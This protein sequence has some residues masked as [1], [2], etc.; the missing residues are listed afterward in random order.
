MANDGKARACRKCW[1]VIVESIE[2][3]REKCRVCNHE[4]DEPKEGE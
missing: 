3:G 1:S 2:N 4:Q